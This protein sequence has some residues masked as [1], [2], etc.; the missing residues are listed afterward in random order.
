MLKSP[1]P[2]Q[3]ITRF[4]LFERILIESLTDCRC[5]KLCGFVVVDKVESEYQFRQR[6]GLETSGN[7]I[8]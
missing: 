4:M 8:K 1:S 3:F 5:R 7:G 6:K 2:L